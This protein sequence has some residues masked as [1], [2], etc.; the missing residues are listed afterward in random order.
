MEIDRHTDLIIKLVNGEAEEQTDL[1]KI[2]FE[3]VLGPV[4]T[5]KGGFTR[6]HDKWFA[7]EKMLRAGAFESAAIMLVPAE[8][9]YELMV[10]L[11]DG[12]K[13]FVSHQ[14]KID[15]DDRNCIAA[16]VPA[17]A[18][19]A[20]AVQAH[21]VRTLDAEPSEVLEAIAAAIEQDAALVRHSAN[22]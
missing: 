16:E 3:L 13:G 8:A 14:F 22:S 5:E 19:A 20:A 17:L 9:G 11:P 15:W 4:R 10:G 6:W 12:P 21:A 18:L 2:A 7:F 1:L